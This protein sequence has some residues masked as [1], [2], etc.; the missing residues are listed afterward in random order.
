MHT[1]QQ[2]TRHIKKKKISSTNNSSQE[3]NTSNQNENQTKHLEESTK[4]LVKPDIEKEIENIFESENFIELVNEY[5]D[6]SIISK[7]KKPNYTRARTRRS[8][9]YS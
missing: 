2:H 1:Y 9:Y 5:S 6:D 8:K 7:E 3:S 4:T